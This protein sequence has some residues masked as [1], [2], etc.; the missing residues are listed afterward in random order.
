MEDVHLSNCEQC[1]HEIAHLGLTALPVEPLYDMRIAAYLIPMRYEA[2]RKWLYRNKEHFPSR[3]RLHGHSHRRIRLLSASEIRLIRAKCLRS[4]WRKSE[5][6]GT[7]LLKAALEVP[8]WAEPSCVMD[9]PPKP[10][11]TTEEAA[12]L[13]YELLCDEEKGQK[14]DC[15]TTGGKR[16]MSD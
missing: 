16:E 15:L 14:G 11:V 4:G 10:L 13:Q 8:S 7:R 2:L 9:A 3:Y 12:E 5:A 6:V 1:G